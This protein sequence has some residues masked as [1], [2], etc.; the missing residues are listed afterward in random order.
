MDARAEL[1]RAFA[2]DTNG[3]EAE[4]IPS[5]ASDAPELVRYTRSIRG[6]AAEL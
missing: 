5:S 6:Y 2:S 4:A 1:E 3:D